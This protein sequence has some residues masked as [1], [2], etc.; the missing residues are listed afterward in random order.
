[1]GRG[2]YL[3][4]Q[5]SAAGG[6]R[7]RDTASLPPAAHARRRGEKAGEAR[8]GGAA[9]FR[10]LPARRGL[11]PPV[12][13]RR[14]PLRWGGGGATARLGVPLPRLWGCRARSV[15]GGCGH[16]GP[17]AAACSGPLGPKGCLVCLTAPLSPQLGSPGLEPQSCPA[18]ISWCSETLESLAQPRRRML[19]QQKAM[20]Q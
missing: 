10:P 7:R 3:I 6:A 14:G 4:T 16:D 15:A 1:M 13:A 20:L 19:K 12:A 8:A 18:D 2:I 17:R 5:K 11:G 9:M